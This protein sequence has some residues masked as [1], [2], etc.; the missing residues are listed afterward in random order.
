[1]YAKDLLG[2]VEPIIVLGLILVAATAAVPR[3]ALVG[4]LEV[5]PV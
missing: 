4:W 3:P 2:A 1:M 5:N